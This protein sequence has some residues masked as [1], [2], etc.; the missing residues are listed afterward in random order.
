[1][2]N[3]MIANVRRRYSISYELKAEQVDVINLVLTKKMAIMAILPTGFGKS[4]LYLLPPLLLDEVS[5]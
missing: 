5:Q 2:D 4:L 1:M 3:S